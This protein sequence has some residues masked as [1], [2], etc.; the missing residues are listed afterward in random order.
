MAEVS[1][2][3]IILDQANGMWLCLNYSHNFM[4]KNVARTNITGSARNVENGSLSKA[5]NVRKTDNQ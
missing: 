4:M 5:F 2:A 3:N 1:N